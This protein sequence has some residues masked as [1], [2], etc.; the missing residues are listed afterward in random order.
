LLPE[1]VEE[2]V[3]ERE[4]EKEI[5]AAGGGTKKG[6]VRIRNRGEGGLEFPKD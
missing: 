2:R 1:P 6:D 5:G 4:R 3:D